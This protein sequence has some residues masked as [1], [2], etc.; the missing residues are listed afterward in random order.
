MADP[1][2][3][4]WQRIIG[5]RD[6]KITQDD[7]VAAEQRFRALNNRAPTPADAVALTALQREVAQNKFDETLDA[8]VAAHPLAD[9]AI[10]K[11][12]LYQESDLNG[13]EGVN[14]FGYAGIAQLGEAEARAA[15]L[16]VN[17]H[18][19]DRLDPLKAIGAAAFTLE[20][21]DMA[22]QHAF[23]S[24]GQPAGDERLKFDLA[25][26]NGGEG[27]IGIAMHLA[28][29]KG[30][31]QAEASGLS[32][33]AATAAA[34]KY[35]TVFDN[36]LEPKNDISQF[37]LYQAADVALGKYGCD[38]N[39]KYHEI[40]QYA[41]DI[42]TRA[43][44]DTGPQLA[45]PGGTSLD[46]SEAAMAATS[47]S[48]L[49]EHGARGTDVAAAQRELGIHA[50]GDFGP[51]TEQAVR[52][53][54][55]SHE[56]AADGVIGAQTRAALDKSREAPNG[57]QTP[58]V[59]L[60]GVQTTLQ[61]IG[62]DVRAFE[63]F[64]VGAEKTLAND[65]KHWIP[66]A[67]A[68]PEAGR[69][70]RPAAQDRAAMSLG[71]QELVNSRI[72]DVA[73]K[74]Y[75]MSTHDAQTH[76]SELENGNLA[77]AYSV[78][79]VLE[80]AL[81]RTYGGANTES[82]PSVMADLERH[83]KEIPAADVQPGDIAIKLPSHGESHG[84]IGIVTQGG[85]D[86]VILNNSSSRGSFTNQDTPAQFSYNYV[87]H[88]QQD[89]VVYL[90]IDPNSVD[91]D[92]LRETPIPEKLLGPDN[93]PP[94]GALPIRARAPEPTQQG[95]PAAPEVSSLPAW[96][97]SGE[98]RNGILVESKSVLDQKNALLQLAIDG[99]KN[100]HTPGFAFTAT[101]GESKQTVEM[102]NQFLDRAVAMHL[103]PTERAA[104]CKENGID[105]G[106]EITGQ[107]G[108]DGKPVESPTELEAKNAKLQKAI[109]LAQ[110]GIVDSHPFKT[111]G[112]ESP[113]AVKAQNELLQA[114]IREN[115]PASQAREANAQEPATR[116]EQL[117]S[118]IEKFNAENSN[119]PLP[120]AREASDWD[121]SRPLAGTMLELGKDEFAVNLG[122]GSYAYVESNQ[123]A[124]APPAP[125]TYVE[126]G[127]NGSVNGEREIAMTQPGR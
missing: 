2:E 15:G 54:Q 100:G 64:T 58:R 53:F 31:K 55:K 89:Q 85:P 117:D 69:E 5:D 115:L 81:G 65:V 38:P 121:K 112:K 70:P 71:D 77:C 105:L 83:G 99:A 49:L 8:A 32:G 118:A 74:L 109:V 76:H 57:Q 124:S 127:R 86:P 35:A 6:V 114:A 34:Q 33:D 43:R 20:R 30:L 41:D 59:H 23:K 21:K 101:P 29:E 1:A 67:S 39:E 22:L 42:V 108:A 92:K 45:S 62:N 47:G 91:L 18:F 10:L 27:T 73:G 61:E 13:K 37:P 102:Q 103:P 25:A 79:K 51:K 60:N 7:R 107:K 87:T 98:T 116:K 26:Y 104:F 72:A 16:T 4:D 48:R 28:Y 123:L 50:D 63:Q 80:T 82:V 120:A 126:I 75:G 97:L 56:L 94:I 84:H 66:E 14:P 68:V 90:R 113:E 122:R 96:H 110:H 119:R 46:V 24:Y 9:A 3:T 11:S 78:N 111:D 52:E 36:L 95:K 17:E 12:L 44:Q 125:N 88:K 19:D 40:S 106:P 93:A